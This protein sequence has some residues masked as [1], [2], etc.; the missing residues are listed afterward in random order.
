MNYEKKNYELRK[1]LH[2]RP[3]RRNRNVP[4][5]YA[6]LESHC[7]V[8]PPPL[9]PICIIKRINKH[10]SMIVTSV[11]RNWKEKVLP[12]AAANRQQMKRLSCKSGILYDDVMATWLKRPMTR[13]P[14]TK[15]RRK[16]VTSQS[17]DSKRTN[18]ERSGHMLEKLIRGKVAVTSQSRDSE[19]DQWRE[20]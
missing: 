19:T 8:P 18:G 15:W 5:S 12:T 2:C 10:M 4:A 16:M 3:W 14:A 11:T 13:A 1:W 6:S 20:G 9:K 7:K 17:R